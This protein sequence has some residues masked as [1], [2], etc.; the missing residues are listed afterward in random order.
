MTPSAEQLP[1]TTSPQRS[2]MGRAARSASLAE[3]RAHQGPLCNLKKAGLSERAAFIL[4]ASQAEG[5]WQDLVVP[6]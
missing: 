6:S 1:E 3:S 4:G 2:R 5:H